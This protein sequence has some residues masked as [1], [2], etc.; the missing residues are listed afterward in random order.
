ME[1]EYNLRPEPRRRRANVDFADAVG[2]V[3]I[4]PQQDHDEQVEISDDVNDESHPVEGPTE[5]IVEW[6]DSV[7][8]ATGGS[9]VPRTDSAPGFSEQVL[10]NTQSVP[11][12][13]SGKSTPNHAKS[14]STN[15]YTNS[16]KGQSVNTDHGT[17]PDRLTQS[18]S[19][20]RTGDDFDVRPSIS[21]T[22][23]R[24]TPMSWSTNHMFITG[25]LWA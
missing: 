10:E 6:E 14:R 11:R 12:G 22:S 1:S 17:K 5:A 20:V 16:Y 3:T 15:V 25:T 2:M 18:P 8:E 24:P 9:S 19:R 4:S 13:T 7:T 23:R 21:S